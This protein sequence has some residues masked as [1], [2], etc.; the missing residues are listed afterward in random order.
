MNIFNTFLSKCNQTDN[1]TRFYHTKEYLRFKGRETLINKAKLTELG[2]TL[3]YN[4]D[5]SSFLAKIHK[6]IHGFESCTG[7]I[8]FKY[9]EAIDVK[10]EELKLCQELDFELFE[11]EKSEPRFPKKGF[12]RLAP[13]IFRMSE[14]QEN[15]SE[16]DAIQYMIQGDLWMLYASITY[17][18]LLIIIL[19]SGKKE[20]SYHWLTPEFTVAKQWLDF[21]TLGYANGITRI[22]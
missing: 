22:G 15:T 7:R 16:E 13:A 10:L 9:L 18:E 8:P 20:P 5:S 1:Y 19:S 6:R 14:F 21:G 2:Q 11:I 12:H 3:G 17:P 4:T